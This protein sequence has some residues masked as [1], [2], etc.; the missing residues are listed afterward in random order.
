MSDSI[1][2]RIEGS[3]FKNVTGLGAVWTIPCTAEVNI[4]F[5]IGGIKFPVHPLDAVDSFNDGKG[6]SVCYG[7]VSSSVLKLVYVSE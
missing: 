2:S 5:K 4:T 1:Y 6:D 7:S 3:A